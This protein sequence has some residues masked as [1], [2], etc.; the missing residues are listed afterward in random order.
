MAKKYKLEFTI[1]RSKWGRGYLLGDDD[2]NETMCA[3]G[4]LG[5]KLGIPKKELRNHSTPF[6]LCNENEKNK[7]KL[8]ELGLLK[9]LGDGE[10]TDSGIANQIMNTNDKLSIHNRLREKRLRELFRKID[11]KVNF[12]N[13]Y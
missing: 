1:D 5:K 8:G 4:F 12:I 9:C 2:G 3:L 10:V 11:I 6:G 7:K 13:R